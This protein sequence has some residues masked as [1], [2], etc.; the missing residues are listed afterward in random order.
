M[1]ASLAAALRA[2]PQ[3]LRQQFGLRADHDAAEELQDAVNAA[4]EACLDGCSLL[5]EDLVPR[6]LLPLSG[7]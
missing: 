1:G 5:V 7:A 6:A 2:S 3:Q 4:A